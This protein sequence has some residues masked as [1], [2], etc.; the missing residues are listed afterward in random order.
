VPIPS[1][2]SVLYDFN[3]HTITYEPEAVG[4][5]VVLNIDGVNYTSATNRTVTNVFEVKSFAGQGSGTTSSHELFDLEFFDTDDDDITLAWAFD[6]GE[7]T[8]DASV[9]AGTATI[10]LTTGAWVELS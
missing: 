9:G 8:E 5:P 4:Q 1:L 2:A 10:N 7:A 3:V 6:S